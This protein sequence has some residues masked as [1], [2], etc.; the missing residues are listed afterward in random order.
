M[1]SDFS[2]SDGLQRLVR[3][4]SAPSSTWAEAVM[5]RKL[6]STATRPGQRHREV[7]D[8]DRPS[9]RSSRAW[10]A[11]ALQRPVEHQ[12]GGSAAS[13]LSSGVEPAHL[14]S[15]ISPI[16]GVPSMSSSIQAPEPGI[17]GVGEL[18]P[19]VAAEHGDAFAR[20]T[21]EL[22]RCTAIRDVVDCA[23]APSVAG[24]RPSSTKRR[25]PNGCGYVTTSRKRGGARPGKVHEVYPAARSNEVNSARLAL[26]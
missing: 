15:S 16:W 19:A 5:S 14:C 7:V 13:P 12:A 10:R 6:L 25:P 23:P 4:P 17:G 9:A 20:L 8:H 18:Q 24:Q 3:A 21:Q 22:S 26:A 2:R 11:L 1:N